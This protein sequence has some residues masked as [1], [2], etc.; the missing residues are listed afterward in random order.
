MSREADQLR[1]TAHAIEVLA[2]EQSLSLRV[3]ADS[4]D[5]GGETMLTLRE[6]AEVAKVRVAVL[7]AEEKKGRIAL[8]GPPRR[9]RVARAE[10]TRWLTETRHAEGDSHAAERRAAERAGARVERLAARRTA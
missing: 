9:R 3:V 5:R 10:L 1:A 4:L 8:H 2:H 6:A 7:A